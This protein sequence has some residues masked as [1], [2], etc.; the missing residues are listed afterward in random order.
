MA[1]PV[2]DTISVGGKITAAWAN[3]DV[4][5]AVNFL[6]A[7]PRVHAYAS[8]AQTLA[9]PTVTLITFDSEQYDTDTMHSTASNTGQNRYGST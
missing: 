2:E 5:D 6:I 7:P 3:S 1:I 8:A 9:S 4:R